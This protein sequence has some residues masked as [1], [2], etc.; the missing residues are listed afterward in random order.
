MINYNLIF[1]FISLIW[2]FITSGQTTQSAIPESYRDEW[3][4]LRPE[5][6]A[7]IEKYRKGDA[8]IE[9]VD[10]NGN[11][12]VNATLRIQQKTHDF[13]FGCNIL[14]L[15]QLGDKNEAYENAFIKLFNLAT[16][17]TC[18]SEIEPEKGQYRFA[19]GAKEIY[20]RPPIDRVLNFCKK[21]DIKLKGQPLLADSWHPKW[22]KDMTVDE[23]H[24]LYKDYFKTIAD[25]YGKDFYMF[26]IVNESFLCK[27][28]NKTR[29]WNFPL[30]TEDLSYSG[31]AFE[32]AQPLFPK[33]CVLSIN[34][35]TGVNTNENDRYF[36]FV[37][38]IF[39]TG[40]DIDAIGFQFHLFTNEILKSHIEGKNFTPHQLIENY[41]K[42]QYF[43]R[44]LY[45]TEI[46]VPTMLIKGPEGEKIQ[47]EVLANFYR[48][49][50]S[51]P[52][53]AGITYWNLCDGVS[54]GKE[55]DA[56]AGLI[57]ENMLEKP[58]YQ[59]LYQ[60]IHREWVTRLKKETDLQGK[61]KFRGFYGKYEV[62]VA[63]GEKTQTFEID[64]S[65]ENQKTNRLIFK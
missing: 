1:L 33:E 50:F 15:G 5:L 42:F 19:A 27:G 4:A 9:L 48:L 43:K 32:A 64:L 10:G 29:G 17:T 30:Y 21:N 26:D 56:K 3:A 28:R 49:W 52:A 55:G 63:I 65:K 8:T 31:W 44:P 22:A 45:I 51:I 7:N 36:K 57:D 37:K 20:R 59:A 11:P 39:D 53:M 12:Q 47:A 38:N 24:D 40:R 6:D 35:A 14:W 54:W 2:P 41:N 58:S 46:T 13:L 61:V 16:T 62:T 18:L 25:R 34:E 60:M 23:T